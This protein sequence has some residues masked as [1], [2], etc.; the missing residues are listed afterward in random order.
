MHE[1]L[2]AVGCGGI[3]VRKLGGDRAG[4][5]RLTRFLRNKSVSIGEMVKVAGERTSQRVSGRHILAIQDTTVIQSEGGG[6]HYLHAMMAVD[7]DDD[8]VLGLIYGSVMSRSKGLTATRTERSIEQKQS[9]RWLEGA[10]AAAKVCATAAKITVIADRESD[11]YEAFERRPKGVD[12][13]IRANHNRALEDGTRLF[14]TVDSWPACGNVSLDLPARAGKAARTINMAVRVGAVSIKKPSEIREKKPISK[15]LNLNFVDVREVNA[16]AGNTP[17][18]W[19]LLTT[20]AVENLQDALKIIELY[21]R[22]WAIE[23]LFRTL[24]TQGFDIEGIRIEEET[25]RSILVVAALIAAVSVQQLVHARDGMECG[26]PIRPLTDTFDAEDAP[27][28]KAFTQ[29]LEGKTKPQQNP[30]PEDSLAY[31]A[32]VCARLGGWN[33][34]Y[35]K[36]GPKTMLAGWLTFQNAKIGAKLRFEINV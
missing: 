16:S 31:G 1:R 5:I 26:R 22:R 18:H 20:H 28:L 19:R 25:P 33:C 15:A 23:Q 36:P 14:A 17:I 35:G 4:E 3:S 34:Y 27:L 6:G 30:H 29:Q 21:R 2:M 10:N 32:W 11:I 24:K 7:A 13:L 12:M 8:A 9:Y